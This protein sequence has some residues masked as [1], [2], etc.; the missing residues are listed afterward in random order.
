M[1]KKKIAT[2]VVAGLITLGV[3]GATFAW[4]TSESTVENKFTTAAVTDG[5][6]VAEEFQEDD[7]KDLYPGAIVDKKV[8]VHNTA[9]YA[10]FIRVKVTPEWYIDDGVSTS[11]TV[12]TCNHT[13][14]NIDAKEWINVNYSESNITNDITTDGYKGKWYKSG[15]Y[16]YYMGAI[17]SGEYTKLLLESV[18]LDKNADSCIANNKYRVIVAAESIQAVLKQDGILSGDAAIDSWG[19]DV[20]IVGAMVSAGN[21]GAEKQVNLP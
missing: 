2:L 19:E 4:F 14:S 1:N 8:Q 16:Y 7:A 9:S 3:V 5:V 21:Q 15:E 10:Q 20:S 11:T 12:I 18:N 17:P 6:E 13:E